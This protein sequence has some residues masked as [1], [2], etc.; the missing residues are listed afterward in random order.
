MSELRR[1]LPCC[2]VDWL[3]ISIVGLAI[4]TLLLGCTIEVRQ[5]VEW[6]GPHNKRT[7]TVTNDLTRP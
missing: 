3:I 2:W 7:V 6:F 4:F 1:L 5:R